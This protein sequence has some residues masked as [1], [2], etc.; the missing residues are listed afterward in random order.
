MA[1]RFIK[2]GAAA[3]MLGVSIPT[4]RKWELSG[5]LIPDRKTEGGTRFY[6]YNKLQ[7]FSIEGLAAKRSDKRERIINQ[8]SG[9]LEQLR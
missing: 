3:D 6:D 8:I 5:E 7:S 2:I 9:L 4:M 1:I